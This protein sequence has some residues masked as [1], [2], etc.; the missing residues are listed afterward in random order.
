MYNLLEYVKFASEETFF[1]F[2]HL[3]EVYTFVIIVI[4]RPLISTDTKLP[5]IL[6]IIILRGVPQWANFT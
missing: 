1:C 3:W 5:H 2:L 4:M 6:I